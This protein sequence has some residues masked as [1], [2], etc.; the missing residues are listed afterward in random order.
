MKAGRQ[1]AGALDLPASVTHHLE[2]FDRALETVVC[3]APPC[4][5]E[6]VHGGQLENS[7]KVCLLIKLFGYSERFPSADPGLE[8]RWHQTAGESQRGQRPGVFCRGAQLLRMSQ[9]FQSSV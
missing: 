8:P 4:F 2:A 1:K 5:A 9:H 6:V 3:L 7:R